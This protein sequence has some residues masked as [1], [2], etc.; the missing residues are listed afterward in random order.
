MCLDWELLT[1]PA[2]SHDVDGPACATC[3]VRGFRSLEKVVRL[4]VRAGGHEPMKVTSR[5]LAVGAQ[6]VTKTPKFRR[7]H[8]SRLQALAA[9]APSILLSPGNS[10]VR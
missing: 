7:A 2:E 6:P 10:S 1:Q 3:F 5:G 9:L 8:Q 4:S